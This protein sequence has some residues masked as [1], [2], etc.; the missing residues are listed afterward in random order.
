MGWTK[1][2]SHIDPNSQSIKYSGKLGKIFTAAVNYVR[3]ATENASFAK[4]LHV[5]NDE[6]DAFADENIDGA[7][8]LSDAHHAH[9]THEDDPSL[10]LEIEF[11]SNVDFTADKTNDYINN[12]DA[13]DPRLVRNATLDVENRS[14]VFWPDENAFYQAIVVWNHSRFGTHTIEYDDGDK[15]TLHLGKNDDFADN[16]NKEESTTK[17][18]NFDIIPT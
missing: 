4:Q 2:V 12:I 3:V 14:K 17:A 7:V 18:N 6:L 1:K 13:E 10:V 8:E 9:S 16:Y 15:E 5:T 11:G